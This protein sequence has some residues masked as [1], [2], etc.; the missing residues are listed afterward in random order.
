KLSQV[1]TLGFP[2]GS[3]SQGATVNVSVTG[4]HVRR[5]FEDLVQVDAAFYGGDS[6]GPIIDTRGKVIGI[7]S[8]VASILA[9]GLLPI[10]IP[11]W[12]MAMVQPITKAAAFLQDLKAG[13]IK[14]NG[15]LD[16]SVEGKVKEIT[17]IAFEGRWA[18]AMALADKELSLSSDP[19]LVTAGAMMHFCAGDDQGARRLFVRSLSMDPENSLARLM[20]YAIDRLADAPSADI[21]RRE[22][23][24]LDWRSEAEFFGYLCRVLEGLVD[25]ETALKGWETES[26]RS[27][28]YYAVG[29][30]RAKRGEWADSE[31]LLREA[32]LAADAETWEFYLSSAKLEEVQKRRLDLLQ[33]EAGWDEYQ[34]SIELFNRTVRKDQ[35]AKESRRA[36]MADLRIQ[37]E[38]PDAGMK[39]RQ[40]TLEKILERA[41]DNG[42]VLV[43]LAFY[44]AMEGSW[45][46][47]LAHTRSFLKRS[48]RQG[49]G[50]LRMGLLEAEILHHMGKQEE[51]RSA[52]DRYARVTR[53]PWFRAIGEGLMGKRTE[54]SLKK[55]AGMSPENLITLYTALGFWAEGSGE[56]ERA[57]DYYKEALESLLDTW[58]EFEFAW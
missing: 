4:G 36:A 24:A 16:L 8:G 47:A 9:P 29:L 27:W 55:E 50:R 31:R 41:P 37:F 6:G 7:A 26:E 34:S 21:H 40:E 20:L 11:L 3:R 22:L 46:R 2:L 51:A 42:D 14:W 1:I 17:R 19:S 38:N 25:E 15:I 54:E 56:K 28:V 12:N 18:D 35:G 32:V 48:G 43:A 39:G 45:D 33:G 57:V 44:S 49:S 52:L 53:D 10:T 5:T 58:D 30:I 13:Q 23:L